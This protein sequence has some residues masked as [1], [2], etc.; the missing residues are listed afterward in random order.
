MGL[1]SIIG[2][3]LGATGLIGIL[4][5]MAAADTKFFGV[6]GVKTLY[7]FTYHGK[8]AS[9]QEED[10]IW[11]RDP[12]YIKLNDNEII[13]S[14]RIVSD[15]GKVISVGNYADD[16]ENKFSSSKYTILDKEK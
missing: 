15:D 9:L 16:R 11:A 4:V 13:A 14:G 12:V 6:R 8:P 5:L 2:L 3:G 10:R 7:S 1:K